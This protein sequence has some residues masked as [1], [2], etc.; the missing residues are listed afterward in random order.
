MQLQPMEI[1]RSFYEEMNQQTLSETEEKIVADIIN[2]CR[3]DEA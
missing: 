2:Q 3:E 1:F